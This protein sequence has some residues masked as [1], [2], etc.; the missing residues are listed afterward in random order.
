MNNNLL[1]DCL[2]FLHSIKD[3]P[4]SLKKLL[5]FM[6]EEFTPQTSSVRLLPDCKLQIDEKYRPL[7]KEAAEDLEMGHIVFVNP[8]TLEMVDIPKDYYFYSKDF[9]DLDPEFDFEFDH[10][11]VENW[12]EMMPPDSCESYKIMES[13]VESLPNG[14]EK[15]KLSI[16]ITG[17][18]PF[19][20]FNRLIHDSDER[21]NWFMFRS[22]QFKKYLIDNY[23]EEIQQKF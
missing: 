17:H 19:A 1:S 6:E 22:N 13:F 15:N 10:K 20:N 2:A 16:A 12:I 8:Q 4:E 21:E 18:K 14:K 5:E 11:K 23:L 7:V 3:N 9:E